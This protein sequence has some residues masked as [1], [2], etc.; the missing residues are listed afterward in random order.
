[1]SLSEALMKDSFISDLSSSD[2]RY[3]RALFS[4]CSVDTDFEFGSPGQ[5]FGRQKVMSGIDV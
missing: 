2:S 4:Y 3:Y 5:R 1:M